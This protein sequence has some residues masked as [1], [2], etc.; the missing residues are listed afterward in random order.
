MKHQFFLGF[1]LAC[2]C[3]SALCVAQDPLIK[4][5]IDQKPLLFGKLPN[6]SLCNRSELDKLARSIKSQNISVKLNADLLLSGVLIE[7]VQTKQ[8]GQN[9]NFRLSNFGNALLTLSIIKQTD[10]K[11]K[12]VGRIIH[13]K[14]G[15][16]L[17][18]AEEN[19]DYYITKHKM[20]FF[21]VE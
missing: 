3:S 9:L 10:N 21:M 7:K 5:K 16:A 19:G 8:G 2:L 11:T 15:D 20:E 6:K 17:V 1:L 18:I 14:H 4:Q 12:I 13:P